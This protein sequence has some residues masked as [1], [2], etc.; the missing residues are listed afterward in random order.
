MPSSSSSCP[1]TTTTT[2]TCFKCAGRGH[3]QRRIKRPRN[4]ADSTTTTTSPLPL[5]QQEGEEALVVVSHNDSGGR[6]AQITRPCHVCTGVGTLASRKK[7]QAQGTPGVVTPARRPPGFQVRGPLPPSPLAVHPEEG[8]ALCCLTGAWRIFQPVGGHRYSTDDV[9]TAWVAGQEARQYFFPAA[10]EEEEGG[11]RAN[12]EDVAS[13]SSSSSSPS[14]TWEGEDLRALDLGCGLGSVL[15]MVCWQLPRLQYQGI[16]AQA[17]SVER[18]RRSL[19]V[20][21]CADRAT[22]HHGDLRDVVMMSSSS[23]S[24]PMAS[25]FDLVTG[26]PPYFDA[27]GAPPPSNPLDPPTTT[28]SLAAAAST[29]TKSGKARP[30]PV[31]LPT[32]EDQRPCNFEMRGG[33]EAY[34]QAATVALSPQGLSVMCASDLPGVEARVVAA[35]AA[36]GLVLVRKVQVE[37]KAGKPSL[38]AVYTMCRPLAVEAYT[39]RRRRMV[40]TG[41]GEAKERRT[42]DTRLLRETLAVREATATTS[43]T[44]GNG[45]ETVLHRRTAAYRR[46]LHDLCM[47]DNEV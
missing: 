16:E 13:S 27:H 44:M 3:V 29:K 40:G 19:L 34:I 24:I 22:I 26:T 21:G 39:H 7:Q 25:S 20:N 30:R 43:S 18:A 10:A 5:L 23:S 14:S 46:L 17:A 36:A 28:T 6:T 38:F 37:P 12:A 11:L 47:P 4:P 9:V 45:V 41:G 1:T 32:A 42:E 2:V 33:V 35:V 8:E 15:L 31:T